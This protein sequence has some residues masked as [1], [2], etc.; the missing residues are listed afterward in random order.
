MT[1][2]IREN[3]DAYFEFGEYR[4]EFTYIDEGYSGSFD[5]NDPDDRQLIRFYA[6]RKSEDGWEDI[7]DGSYCTLLDIDTPYNLLEIFAKHIANA[8]DNVS[9]KRALEWLT[10]TSRE[11]LQA[12]ATD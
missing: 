7:E 9:P 11:E 4:V 2:T 5:P 10:W 1:E 8:S 6:Q 3:G 12:I